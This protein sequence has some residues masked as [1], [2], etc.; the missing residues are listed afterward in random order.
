MATSFLTATLLLE[1][2]WR[3]ESGSAT[4]GAP[5]DA[6][7]L[8]V[9][10]ERRGAAALR[11]LALALFGDLPGLF[12]VL[13]AHGEGERAQP[14]LGDLFA[15][16]E[17]VAVV[18]LL[19]PPQRVVDLVE[20]LRLHLD[21]RELDVLL[22]VG[23]GALHGVEHFVE[24][25]APGA[26]SSH[27]AHFALNLGLNLALALLEHPL[28]LAIAGSRRLVAS[29]LL[30]FPHD[31]APSYAQPFGPRLCVVRHANELPMID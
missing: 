31:A 24:L 18:A 16:V 3:R 11:Q 2:R 9:E 17:A 23:L 10:E 27:V 5:M 12:T 13:A 6:G 30:D 8:H 22:N 15:A 1:G 21:E 14:L 26:L 4:G 25:A 7:F 19:E 29:C 20:R 28:E